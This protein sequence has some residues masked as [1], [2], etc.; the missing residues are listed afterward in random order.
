MRHNYIASVDIP[1]KRNH[2][3]CESCDREF[4]VYWGNVEPKRLVVSYGDQTV[5]HSG[6]TVGLDMMMNLEVND[7]VNAT[8]ELYKGLFPDAEIGP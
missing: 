6:M 4:F 7:N 8:D 2:F 1:N 5:S 3:K